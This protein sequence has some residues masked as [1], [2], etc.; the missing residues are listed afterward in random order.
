MPIKFPCPNCGV[1]RIRHD[2]DC[3]ACNYPRHERFDA[4]LVYPTQIRKQDNSAYQFD[5]LFLLVCTASTALYFACLSWWG[6]HGLQQRVLLTMQ[7]C[8]ILLP[9]LLIRVVVE[10]ILHWL[11]DKVFP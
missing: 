2:A 10:R 3:Q 6:F 4:T 7:I 5:I 8:T 11:L 9:L 1:H